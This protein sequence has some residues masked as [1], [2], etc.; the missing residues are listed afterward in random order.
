MS[1]EP[2]LSLLQGSVGVSCVMHFFLETCHFFLE[3]LRTF[4]GI[5]PSVLQSEY[6]FSDG[7]TFLSLKCSYC[8][9]KNWSFGGVEPSEGLEIVPD[10]LKQIFLEIIILKTGAG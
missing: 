6:S 4:T 10:I 5:F 9:F 3:I 2:I 8:F 1:F 7:G